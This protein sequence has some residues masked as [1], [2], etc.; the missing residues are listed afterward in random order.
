VNVNIVARFN[1]VGTYVLSIVTVKGPG[2]DHC[3]RKALLECV[4][5]IGSMKIFSWIG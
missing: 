2:K 5:Q 3:F 1:A 4:S